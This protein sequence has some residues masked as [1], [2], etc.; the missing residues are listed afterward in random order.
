MLR[1]FL[2]EVR[3]YQ[4]LQDK[5]DIR[6]PRCYYAQIIAEGPEFAAVMEDLAP[7]EQGDQLLGCSPQV[8]R[9]AVQE[10]V[11]LHGPGW[12]DEQLTSKD[13]LKAA[14][15][16]DVN[17]MREMYRAQLPGF[18]ERYGANLKADEQAIIARVGEVEHA[19]LFDPLPETFSLVHV[20][21]RLDNLLIL[22]QG[23]QIDVTVVDWQSITLGGF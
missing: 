7:A 20:D 16:V 18:L 6:T 5:L 17:A 4:E 23:D 19:P 10:L 2:K 21:Y 3:F 9:A 15:V 22:D 8:A 1:N 11:G 13:W 14:E 12:C